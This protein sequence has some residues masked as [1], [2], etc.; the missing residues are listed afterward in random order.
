MYI[1]IVAWNKVINKV[2][3]ATYSRKAFRGDSIVKSLKGEIKALVVKVYKVQGYRSAKPLYN[4]VAASLALSAIVI[5]DKAT[6][7]V[8]V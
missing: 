1:V 5:L 4:I 2:Y 7:E 8:L 6:K 3:K